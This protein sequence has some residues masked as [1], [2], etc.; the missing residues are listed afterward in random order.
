[1]TRD[2]YRQQSTAV[3]A[4][5]LFF[6]PTDLLDY[7]GKMFEFVEAEGVPL[8]RL[9]FEDGMA[10]RN[11]GEIRAQMT[12]LS[13]A[14]QVPNDASGLPPFLLFHGSADA[15]VPLSQSQK[16]VTALK[17][18]GGHAELV[19]KDGGGHPWPDIHQEIGRLAY[20][21]GSVL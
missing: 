1:L 7:A 15:V 12:A 16:L 10:G 20:W 19:I 21:F 5:G 2:P 9:L 3:R 8:D 6:P 4:V 18:A 14:R 17:A 13:P 11:A